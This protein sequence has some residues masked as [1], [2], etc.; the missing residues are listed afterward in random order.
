M[1][2]ESAFF[3]L[4]KIAWVVISPDALLLIFVLLLWI[5]VWRGEGRL[6]KLG[7]SVLA[8]ILLALALIPSGKWLLSPLETRFANNPELPGDVNGI[9]VLGGAEN[10][11][12]SAYWKQ[13]EM[14]EASERIFAFL[15]LARRYPQAKLVFTGGSGA[16]LHQEHKSADIA[17][18]VLSELGM[19]VSRIIFERNSRN[20]H[21]NAVLSKQ[22]AR[23]QRGEKW[24][25]ITSAFHMPRSVGVFCKAEWPVTPY[26]VDHRTKGDKLLQLGMSLSGHLG[27]LGLAIR[28]WLGLLTYYLTGKTAQILPSGCDW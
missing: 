28:E 7:F 13:A 2:F 21:E 12:L 5:V 16:V 24:I 8:T 17:R 15:A 3:L 9:I 23:P 4:S 14:N 27:D 22:L 26:P 20:T 6:A 25:L 18:I 11:V 10:I 19:D 1:D